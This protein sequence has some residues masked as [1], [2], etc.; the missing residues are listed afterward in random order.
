MLQQ[1]NAFTYLTYSLVLATPFALIGFGSISQAPDAPAAEAAPADP[2]APTETP[3]PAEPAAEAP[4]PAEKPAAAEPPAE[5]KEEA[6]AAKPPAE[7]TPAKEAPAEAA[8]PAAEVASETGDAAAAFAAKLDEWKSLLKELRALQT[9]YNETDE[10]DLVPV[11]KE[12]N[13]KMAVGET[14]I[15]E[16]RVLGARAYAAAPNEDRELARFLV[17]IVADDVDRD[18]FEDANIVSQA[19]ID[20]G[21]DVGEVFS[22]GAIAA[23]CTNDF[24]KAEAY[25]KLATERGQVSEEAR[26]YMGLLDE[27]RDYWEEEKKIR[28][29]EAEADDLPRVKM[30]TSKGDMIVELFENEA[31]GA[32]GNFISLVEKGYYDG[33]TFHRVLEHF[34][35]QGGCPQGTGS[36]GPGYNIYCETKGNYRK[37]FR[38]TLSMAHAGPDTGGSQFFVTFVPTA[39]LNGL[40][41]AFGRVIEGFDVLSK[42]ERIDPSAK[43]KPQPD[44]IE[45][46]EVI[47]KR[48]HEYKPDKVQ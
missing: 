24:D 14:L 1:K 6:P 20:N 48:D 15:D 10:N 23:F 34:M 13:D 8:P 17:K 47:R 5:A 22:Q 26:K 25:I 38:G 41:T 28:A 45:K 7:A 16:L 32:V 44:V 4:T 42:L 11:L 39:H 30:T 46:I 31:P 33:L 19:L 21:T 9:K 29:Q 12:W 18:A 3:A 40:H 35:A 43:D 2:P 27:Y 37:H 36:G